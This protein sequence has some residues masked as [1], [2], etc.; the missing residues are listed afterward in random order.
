[1]KVTG[2]ESLLLDRY[3]IV[4]VHTD[5]GIV[6]L[7]ESGAWGHLEASRAA[8]EKFADYLVGQDPFRIEHHWN[9]MYRSAYFHGAAIMGALS[10]IDIALWD[11]KGK[12]LGVPVYE[13]M[14]GR[15]RDRA[16]VYCH[17]KGSTV[18]RQVEGCVA[19]RRRGFTAIGHLNPLLDEPRDVP[20]FKPHV[21]MIRDAIENVRRYREAVGD[22]VDLCIEIHRR[23]TPADAIVLG[24]GIEAFHPLFYE[25]PIPP[26]SVDAM[27]MVAQ[28]VGTPIATGERLHTPRQFQALLAKGAAQYVRVSVCLCGG[29]T[30]ARKVAALAEAHHVRVAPHSPLSPVSLAA[31]LQLDASIPNFAIQEYPTTE[32]EDDRERAG[33][34]ELLGRDL[35]RSLPPL[36][37]GFVAIPDAPGIGVELV[38]D[39]QGRFPPRPRRV[40]VRMH[41]DGSLVDQ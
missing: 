21:T 7:G 18:E 14:G 19:A 38:P 39:V 5:R 12:A 35:V 36:T 41:V 34:F 4:R 25:D 30:G 29:L 6:G 28:H 33:G 9:V 2:V 32:L 22:D 17:V 40:A 11:L 20:Y 1:M 37:D 26:D 10:A 3:L 15:C 8:V 27:A 16:R 31:C 24:R 23:L 13:L